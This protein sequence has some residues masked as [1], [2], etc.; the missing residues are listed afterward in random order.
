MIL[1]A[2]ALLPFA[3]LDGDRQEVGVAF[4]FPQPRQHVGIEKKHQTSAARRGNGNRS[5][6][7]RCPARRNARLT[8][9]ELGEKRRPGLSDAHL[10][11]AD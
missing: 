2:V 9:G 10:D 1:D 5:N 7:P 4:P 6:A 3:Q 8:E 11:R